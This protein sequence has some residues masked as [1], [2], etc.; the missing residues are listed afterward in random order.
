MYKRNDVNLLVKIGVVASYGLMILVNVLATI[1]PLNNQTTA[2]VSNAYPNLFAPAGLTFSIWGLIYLMLLLF[3]LY[4]TGIISRDK[5]K[6]HFENYNRIG[7][8]FTISALANTIWL[9]LWHYEAFKLSLIFMLVMLLTL[10]IINKLSL[11]ERLSN[12]EKTFVKLPFSIYLGWIT[13]ATIANITVYLV[14]INWSG[15]NLSESLWTVIVIIIGFIIGASYTI[16]N[17]DF[18]YGLVI[19][20][21]YIGIFIKHLSS[22]GFNSKYPQIMATTLIAIIGL[23]ISLVYVFF[24]K[25]KKL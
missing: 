6:I 11:D 17:K 25:R 23:I 8:L 5:S 9:F 16:L 14:S 10:I 22:S 18:A 20:W 12:K 15:L 19:V 13:I 4:F 2:D 24:N 21:A 3:V 1:L 7:I